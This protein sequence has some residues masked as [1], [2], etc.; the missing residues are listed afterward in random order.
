MPAPPRKARA[1]AK[2]TSKKPSQLLN[3]GERSSEWLR[4]VG[5][6]DADTLR[7]VGAVEAYRRLKAAFPRQ[8]SWVALYAIHGALTNTH[9]ND[10]PPEVKAQ[11]R[12][13]VTAGDGSEYLR[14]G[15]INPGARDKRKE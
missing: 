14:H 8:V 9:W 10:F 15:N 1:R 12:D 5:I 11:M 4:A 7:A 3:L 6:P 13:E 2:R